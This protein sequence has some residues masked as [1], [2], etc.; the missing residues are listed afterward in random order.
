[1]TASSAP[2]H[3]STC[4][5]L[6]L[7]M[8]LVLAV[9][10]GGCT[11]PPQNDASEDFARFAPPVTNAIDDRVYSAVRLENGLRVLA[12]SD[13]FTDTA[14]AALAVDVGSFDEDDDRLGLAHFLE[15]MLFL[16]TEKY[17]DPNEYGEYISARGGSRNAYTSLDH[18]NYFFSIAAEEFY[19][20]LDRFAQFFVAPLFTAELVER[21]K[22]AVNSEY[23]MQ[24]RDDG[25]RTYMTQKRALN[26]DHPGSRFTIGSLETLA[27][28]DGR[29]VRDDLLE[30]YD[31]H[32]T[33][34]GMALVLLGREDI[35]TLEAWA[36]ELFNAVPSR[37]VEAERPE[38][39]VLD[40]ASLP[41]LMYMQPVK[42]R[43]VL[44]LSFE[45]PATDPVYTTNAGAY[46]A[47]LIGH[48]GTGSL[49][50]YLTRKGWIESLSAG[51]GRF[52]SDATLLSATIE[53]TPEGLENWETVGELFFAYVDALREGGID[54]DRYDEQSRLADLGFRFREKSDAF[55]YVRV[56]ASNMLVFPTQ[57]VVRGPSAFD[58]YDPALITEFLDHVRPER[59]QV[60]LIAPD[61]PTDRIERWFEVPY[62]ITDLDPAVL[63]R[64]QNPAR[65]DALA[66]PDR[67]PFVPESLE[68]LADG[69][70][71]PTQ[72][73]G[74]DGVEL[75]H[76]TDTEFGS[77]RARVRLRLG[78]DAAAAT[79]A[80]VVAAQ[81]Y[82]RL[83]MDAL[84][85]YAYPARLAGLSFGLS[86][87]GNG[88]SLAVGGFDDKLDTLLERVTSTMAELEIREDRFA[89]FRAE[90]LKDLRNT[91]QD[92]PYQQT[93][94]ELRR[95]L[96]EPGYPLDDMIAAAEAI[97]EAA[98]AEWIDAVFADPDA[99]VFVHGNADA[100]TARALATIARDRL[101]LRPGASAA[102]PAA[103]ITLDEAVPLRISVPVEHSDAALTLYVQ[104]RD[105]TWP[106]RARFGLLAHMMG[107]SYFNDLRT[108]RQ[109][110]YVVTAQPWVQA[111]TP[112]I[113]FLVQSPV[114]P[115]AEIEAAT[116]T[117][118]ENFTGVLD[119][120]DGEA[121]A[122]EK[123]GLLS[124][125][126]EADKNLSERSGRLWADLQ[127]ELESFDS[128]EEIAAAI[129]ALELEDMRAFMATFREL[130]ARDRVAVWTNGRFP[131][132]AGPSGVDV[133]DTRA[134]RAARGRYRANGLGKA[135]DD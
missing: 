68:L 5:F 4:G 56:L 92:R 96:R 127:A 105:Q 23:Q 72:L 134:F 9:A 93:L 70:V 67:N 79:P 112:G 10:N 85:E 94:S 115:A 61:L 49:H 128:R 99:L 120:M 22:N 43:R 25:W 114:A 27:D 69:G 15:H 3:H 63:E 39:P 132:E 131:P 41:S 62:A 65:P 54:A 26:P 97:D 135:S 64:W 7:A 58:N 123:A 50:A 31:R 117:F 55:G 46:L 16:G 13:S 77:P 60:A 12:I 47:N 34:D 38:V 100:S 75:W 76:L 102:T 18:T 108:E 6:A 80:A 17:P 84:N 121:F 89:Q 118:L 24:L 98:L 32:Y 125:V 130:Y 78:T 111:N 95:L 37:N 83:V 30:F 119:D 59:T 45:L 82:S 35:D 57:D 11:A 51:A 103:I 53:L 91:R 1:M 88:L 20:G 126:L 104:G 110:G 122:A 87:S 52:G 29:S 28:R 116:D 21:E 109:L 42:E 2:F 19:G 14:A 107:A 8:T 48:E 81:L 129:D 113:I 74:V 44:E 86:P 66:L 71:V 36:V 124:K 40:P 73:S 90:L 133:E 101:G 33:A 106:E